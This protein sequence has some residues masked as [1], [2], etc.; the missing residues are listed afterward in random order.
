MI[1]NIINTSSRSY[2]VSLFHT[3]SLPQT[4]Y[5][6][7]K[8][9]R[10]L[11]SYSHEQHGF[12]LGVTDPEDSRREFLKLQNRV[13]EIL[14]AVV[15]NKDSSWDKIIDAIAYY[16]QKDGAIDGKA[17]TG[18]MK[19]EEKEI[20]VDDKGKFRVSLYKIM[21]FMKVVESIKAG[22]LNLS[23][24]YK[25]RSLDE[26]LI[27][28]SQ[29]QNNKKALIKQADLEGVADFK[30]TL[31][32]LETRL[33]EGFHYINRNI[34]EERNQLITFSKKG[35]HLST[36]TSETDS[37]E[38]LAELFPNKQYIAL[39]EVLTTINRASHFLD[40]FEHWQ[41][42]YNRARPDARTFIAAII[43]YGCNIGPRRIAKISTDLN[44]AEI[45][46]TV[47]WYFSIDNV[48][49]AT[50]RILRFMDKLDLPNVYRKEPDK[51]HTSSD[52]QKFEVA[53]DSLNANYS[54]KYFGQNRGV[55]VYSFIDERHL[56]FYSMVISA[57]E[58]EA[59]YVI[60]GLMHNDVIKSDIHST[61]THG[62]SEVVF[63]VMYL[64]G[65]TFA[66]RIKNLKDQRIYS[67]VKK[68]VYAQMGYKLLPKAYINVKLIEENQD[69][70]LRFI[71]TIKLKVST[72]S[73]LFKRL[74]SYSKRHPLYRA[75]KEFGKIVKSI[76]ILRYIDDPRFRQQIEKQ[77]NKI[78]SSHKFAKAISFAN[79]QE[80]LQGTK[81]E[82][83][84]AESCT[85]LIENAI[86]CWNYL[87]CS[88]KI[89]N[90]KDDARRA[91]LIDII[92]NGSMATGRHLN[93][94]GE[95]DFSD[96]KLEDSVGLDI[97]RLVNLKLR[98]DE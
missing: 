34:L 30:K 36:P 44:E 94:H 10:W 68:K 49:N 29:W 53:V 88:Q 54:Y 2:P 15:F 77:V 39:S 84:V 82:Q 16:R 55:S 58:R 75:L 97:N 72:A 18:F 4:T 83:E 92:R 87:Y 64:L 76:F 74:N 27:E 63:A 65:F 89:A 26:Y 32:K 24:S 35:F 19:A 51:L 14:K 40:A 86:V 3:Y 80:L 42:K 46:N 41:A 57:S 69:E 37:T 20:L 13:S 60:D 23:Y 67:F 96:E 28:Q 33:D 38:A 59:A 9:I 31:S 1:P 95:Y 90:E 47:N 11:Y 43:G 93:L 21:L 71:A 81:E 66:P 17:P 25:Y 8:I 6:V 52:G 50:N 56:L 61:D 62:Y 7:N 91:E 22:K 79:N 70:I 85:R 73:Q 98:W 5:C 12:H 48:R 45:E 78:E